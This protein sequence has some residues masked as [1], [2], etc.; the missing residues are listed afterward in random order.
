M[1]LN[2]T[3]QFYLVDEV[4][5][6]NQKI[7]FLEP[8]EDNVELTATVAVGSRTV[9]E[10]A[11]AVAN[12]MNSIGKL[13]Y[14]VAFDRTTR[15]ITISSTATFEL[16]PITGSNAGQSIFPL[17]GFTTDRSGSS[18]YLADGETGRV[19]VPQ[20]PVQNYKESKDNKTAISP[21]VNE[22]ASGVKEIIR[23]G[24]IRQYTFNFTFITDRDMGDCGNNPWIN[25]PNAVA[26]V[27]DF[28]DFSTEQNPLE[29]MPD[30][31]DVNT[32]LKIQL[33]RTPKSRTGT[34]YELKELINKRLVGY[35]DTGRLVFRDLS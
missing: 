3:P 33:D 20:F 1:A 11:N 7:N 14:T 26:E 29:Y 23:F 31:E 12:A 10:L 34:D 2:T 16:Y 4:T 21:S 6:D 27:N 13:V 15:F 18:S 19:Y 28:L 24:N 9:T 17:I 30:R 35:Y 8:T 5:K 25:N 32:F 22:S